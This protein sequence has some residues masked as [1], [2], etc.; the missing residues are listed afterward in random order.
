MARVVG[1]SGWVLALDISQGMIEACRQRVEGLTQVE[2]AQAALEDLDLTPASFD[3]VICH[4]VFPHFDNKPRA[5]AKMAKLLGPGG[6]LVVD[7][8]FG[9]AHINDTHRKAGTVVEHDLLPSDPEMRLLLEEAGFRVDM[10]ADDHLG[11]F[12]RATLL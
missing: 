1:R 8:F 2:V 12:V 6:V 5:L 3:R 10:M 9:A 4:Q 11:Y 7:H